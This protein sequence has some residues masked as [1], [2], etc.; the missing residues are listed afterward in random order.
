MFRRK[1]SQHERATEYAT[2][3]D[4]QQI[5]KEDMAGLHLLAYLLTADKTKAEQCFV[6]GLEDSIH[7]NLVFKQWARTWSKRAIIQNAIKTVAPAVAQGAA[8]QENAAF[9]LQN[10]NGSESP[11]VSL[12]L[13]WAAF[14]RFVFV[15]SVLEGY[16][17]REC[18]TLLACTDQE[19]IAAKSRV[20]ERLADG[21]WQAAAVLSSPRWNALFAHAQV[22]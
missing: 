6:A 18:A 5:F 9:E 15:M 12:V 16:A 11:L 21:S 20:L 1:Q 2:C 4:F 14:E 19:I 7:G 10:G 17:V 13:Q 22:A 3:K 8:V